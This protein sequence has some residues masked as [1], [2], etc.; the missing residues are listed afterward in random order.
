MSL[1]T[2]R[3]A[4]RLLAMVAGSGSA[5]VSQRSSRTAFKVFG[6]E[7]QHWSES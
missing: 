4:A 3:E 2:S 1:E 7:L 6:A 5:L